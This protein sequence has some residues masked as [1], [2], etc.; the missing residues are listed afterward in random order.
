MAAKRASTSSVGSTVASTYSASSSE[1]KAAN[2][3]RCYL[4]ALGLDFVEQDPADLRAMLFEEGV[5]EEVIEHMHHMEL[6]TIAA[7][8]LM[9]VQ[10]ELKWFI[11]PYLVDFLIEIHQTFA[12]APRRCSS[13]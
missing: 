8:E 3:H 6:Q 1:S 10:P 7:V 4:D 12:C 5:P 11:A 9:D 13:P 2:N